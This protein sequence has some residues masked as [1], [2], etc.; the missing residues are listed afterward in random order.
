MADGGARFRWYGHACVE[1]ETASGTVVLIDPWLS[2][3]TSPIT[4]DEIER[5]D[6]LLVTHGHDDHMGEAVSLARR[7]GPTWPAIHELSLWAMPQ[8]GPGATVI[9]MNKGG[10]VS[11]AGVRVT[12][13][14]AEHSAGGPFAGDAAVHQGEPVGVVI[15]L[16]DGL[17]IYHSGDTDVFGDMALIRELHAPDIAFLSIGGHYTMDP[18]G[19]AKAVELLGVSRVVPIHWGTFD[20]LAGTPDQLRSALEARGLVDVQVISPARGETVAL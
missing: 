20:I 16:E 13:V 11:A 6:V 10:T 8:C 1:I 9:G 3:P 14:H 5:V 7:L 2:N 17:R 15:E 4:A 18:R 19:A 12:M